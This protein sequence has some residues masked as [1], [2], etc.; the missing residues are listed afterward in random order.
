[1]DA[2]PQ[3][4]FGAERQLIAALLTE[5]A[6]RVNVGNGRTTIRVRR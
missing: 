4:S 5:T 2:S 6:M 1:M 3:A